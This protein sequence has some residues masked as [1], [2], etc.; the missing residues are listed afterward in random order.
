MRTLIRFHHCSHFNQIAI[1]W[2]LTEASIKRCTCLNKRKNSRSRRTWENYITRCLGRFESVGEKMP[3]WDQLQTVG[4]G[5][6]VDPRLRNSKPRWERNAAMVRKIWAQYSSLSPSSNHLSHTTNITL[7]RI[8]CERLYFY[9]EV[10]SFVHWSSSLSLCSAYIYTCIIYGCHNTTY[11]IWC[12]DQ[13]LGP[14]FGPFMVLR[15]F[16]KLLRALLFLGGLKMHLYCTLMHACQDSQ[17]R[18]E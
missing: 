13:D 14:G 9:K 18:K 5:P 6:S 8:M 2:P 17:L 7:S 3:N 16:K 12:R 11:S 4:F 1:Y 10:Y 15:F